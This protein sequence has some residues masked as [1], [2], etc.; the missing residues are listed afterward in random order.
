MSKPALIG[1]AGKARAGKDTVANFLIAAHGGY[2]Y[3]FADPIRAMLLPLGIDMN[4][5]YWQAKKEEVIPVLGKSPREL[6]QTLGTEWGR[7]LVNNDLWLLLAYQRLHAMGPGM[8]VADVRF[9]NEADWIRRHDGLVIHLV[10]DEASEVAA[11][12]SEAGVERDPRD[13]VLL[14]NGT[15]EALQATVRGLFGGH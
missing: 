11:H 15:L 3:G 5:P 8:V 1:I 13:L 6:M 2:R 10:R 4:D 9:E 14:N 7:K 12:S